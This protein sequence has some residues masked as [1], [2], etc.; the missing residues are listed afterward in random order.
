MKGVRDSI[1]DFCQRVTHNTGNIMP[2]VPI[3]RH[4][5]CPIMTGDYLT[6][7]SALDIY[8]AI[9]QEVNS[10]CKQHRHLAKATIVSI[11]RSSSL[12][13]LAS[14]APFMFQIHRDVSRQ[15][16]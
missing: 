11:C 2:G 3:K 13:R 5:R 10:E 15:R 4:F 1:D 7:S 8:I 6:S 14:M 16:S 9:S 12:F